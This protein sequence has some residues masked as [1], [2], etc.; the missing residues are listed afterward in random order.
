MNRRFNLALIASL[1]LTAT[2]VWAQSG[3]PGYTGTVRLTS[4]LPAGS[5][6]DVVARLVADKLQ[7]RWGQPVVVDPKP[8]G[9]GAVAIN[10]MKNS[11]PNGSNLVVVDVQ[12]LS[13]NPLIFKSL[14][15]DPEKDLTPVAILYK[16]AFLVVVASD[17][18]YRTFKDLLAAARNKSKPLKYGSNSVG[19]PIHLSSARLQAALG[20][21]ML[22]VPYKETSLLYAAVASGELDWSYGSAATTAPLVKGGKLRVLAIADRQRLASFPDVP[23]LEEA[24]GPKGVDAL[25]WVA[26]MAPAGTPANVVNEMNTGIVQ[27]LA[28]PDVRER[29]AGFGFEG[30][31]G[32]AQQVADW[33]ATDRQRYAE[34]I[35]REK[36][37][38]D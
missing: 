1:A 6:P 21:D 38:V 32:P 20:A 37:S 14:S 25:S 7:T 30:G 31:T 29:L 23:T 35:K 28:Q 26:L 9:G 17:S 22:H 5:G 12:Q 34:V 10:A 13:I 19:G 24:G 3:V 8:G 4:T 15:Y 11:P 36:I 18:P 2:G 27:A 16:T 33:A